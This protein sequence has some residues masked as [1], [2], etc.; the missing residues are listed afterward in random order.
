MTVKHSIVKFNGI[1]R[2]IEPMELIG[3][4]VWT[5][6]S[7]ISFDDGATHRIKGFSK[8]ADALPVGAKPVFVHPVLTPNQ[9][10]WIYVSDDGVTV[11]VY[12]TDGF[13]HYDI[14]PATG[15][16][17]GGAGIWTGTTLNG[18]PVLNNGRDY[19]FWWNGL[20]ASPCTTLPDWPVDQ[21]CKSIR[22]YKYHLVALNLTRAT[23]E[24]PNMLA[25]SSAADP[26][27]VPASWTPLPSNDAGDNTLS[28]EL[29]GLVD[30]EPLR[31]SLVIYRQH[32]TAVCNYI[33]GQYVFTFR[34]LFN[35]SGIQALNCAVEVRG[36]HYVLTDDDIIIHDGNQ[37]KTISDNIIRSTVFAGISPDLHHLCCVSARTSV[38]EVWFCIPTLD[39]DLLDFAAIFSLE[40]ES[41][42]HRELPNLAYLRTGIIPA[43]TPETQ[44][45]NVVTTWN[46]DS[47]RWSDANYSITNDGMIAADP[48]ADR[49]LHIDNANDNDGDDVT[50]FIERIQ[51]P[52][53][54]EAQDLWNNVTARALWPHITGTTGDTIQIRLGGSQSPL[55]PITWSPTVNFTIGLPEAP[56][57]DTFAY[58]RFI[59]MRFSSVG[60]DPWELHRI[61][62][63]YVEHGKF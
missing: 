49:L 25:W 26:G 17:V 39:S 12:V 32:S 2:D 1:V 56:K 38:D 16:T 62:M 21:Y 27:A 29:G 7:N 48:T 24:F 15:L 46:T 52:P 13:T 8:F 33:A 37:F 44:W 34:E 18:L 40:T 10:Y 4:N 6:G 22:A 20:T 45:D 23:V 35:T 43:E 53:G 63:E 50:A 57:V 28:E 19:P 51:F 55:A 11:T 9:S 47:R 59:S 31:D 42:G 3:Q 14:T 5:S 36:K 41:F 60:G 54:G 61:G 30:A 58:G